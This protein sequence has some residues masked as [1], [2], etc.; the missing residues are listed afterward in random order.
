MKQVLLRDET[1]RLLES[2]LAATGKTDASEVVDEV[3]RNYLE[4][5][6]LEKAWTDADLSRLSEYESYDW[7]EAN[8]ETIGKPI[9][10]KVGQG[11]MGHE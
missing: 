1:D 11:F 8:P 10:Y 6:L 3:L 4:D 5:V 2:Y 9:T 7:G